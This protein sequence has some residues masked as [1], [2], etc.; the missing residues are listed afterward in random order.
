[1]LERDNALFLWLSVLLPTRPAANE[2]IG[3]ETLFLTLIQ[4]MV[5][6]DS[7][8]CYSVCPQS[9]A[10]ERRTRRTFEGA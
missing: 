2:H 8:I 6:S 7:V 1:M 5:L 9:A 3:G 10:C 4:S